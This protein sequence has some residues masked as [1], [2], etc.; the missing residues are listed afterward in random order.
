MLWASGLWSWHLALAVMLPACWLLAAPLRIHGEP[1]GTLTF[2]YREPHEFRET[3][4][5]V[6][7]A[8]ANPASFARANSR[9][10]AE[11]GSPT[12]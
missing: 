1:C 6:V 7:T 12:G 3:E 10:P 9:R 5:R 4:L 8:L 11:V 2:Y